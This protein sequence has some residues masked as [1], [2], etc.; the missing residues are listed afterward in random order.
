MSPFIVSE[1]TALFHEVK[2][3]MAKIKEFETSIESI[4]K[5]LKQY[6]LFQSAPGVGPITG[7]TLL[8]LLCNPEVL[9]TE[10]NLPPI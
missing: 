9:R 1:L 6:E 4:A 3:A 10:E 8:V 7:A 2:E 5:T